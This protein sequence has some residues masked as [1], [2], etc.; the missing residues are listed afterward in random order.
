MWLKWMNNYWYILCYLLLCASVRISI[1]TASVLYMTCA[2]CLQLHVFACPAYVG[3]LMTTFGVCSS[4]PPSPPSSSAAMPLEQ[5]FV[6]VK[7]VCSCCLLFFYQRFY[8]LM[9]KLKCLVCLII[10]TLTL[11]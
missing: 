4:V 11:K 9:Q 5:F 6:G 1:D 8:L 10:F 7:Q 2:S 3:V